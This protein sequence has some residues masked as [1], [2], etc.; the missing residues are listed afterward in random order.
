MEGAC[1]YENLWANAFFIFFCQY[2]IGVPLI[3]R[4]GEVIGVNIY[5][6]RCTPF[7]PIN[8]DSKC[9]EHF[10]KYRYFPNFCLHFM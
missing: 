4:N 2:G 6:K 10:E 1:I 3:N 8:I 5:D 9:L 7:L